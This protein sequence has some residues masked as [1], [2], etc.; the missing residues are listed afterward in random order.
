MTNNPNARYEGDVRRLARV[1]AQNRIDGLGTEPGP[2][3]LP[4][5]V[6]YHNGP[7]RHTSFP[8]ANGQVLND[9]PQ[10]RYLLIQNRGAAVAYVGFGVNN[11]A[12]MIQIVAGGNYELIYW[13]PT[14]AVYV[15]GGQPIVIVEI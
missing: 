8:A 15:I 4:P 10:R 6:P 12:Q 13:V 2:P 9:N 3:V 14:N 1:A 7:A 11:Q 5:I